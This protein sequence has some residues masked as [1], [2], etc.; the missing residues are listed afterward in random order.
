MYTTNRNEKARYGRIKF[1]HIG[2]KFLYDHGG[3]TN[4]D[5]T[6]GPLTPMVNDS[7]KVSIGE[8]KKN[9]LAFRVNATPRKVLGKVLTGFIITEPDMKKARIRRR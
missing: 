1:V 5:I 8:V 4:R 9:D 6:K 2:V 7:G 3:T